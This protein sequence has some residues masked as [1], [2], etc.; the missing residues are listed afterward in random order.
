MNP[1]VDKKSMIFFIAAALLALLTAFFYLSKGRESQSGKILSPYFS[2]SAEE[3]KPL[4]GLK[5]SEAITPDDVISWE[6]KAFQMVGQ[7]KSDATAG[8][9]V[10]CLPF[11]SPARFRRAVIPKA[12]KILGRHRGGLQGSDLP[13]LL[14]ILFEASIG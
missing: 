7:T 1:P 9:Q 3:L 8:V 11:Y 6:E 2:Y 12:G 4:V 14:R 5:A 10:L 13:L